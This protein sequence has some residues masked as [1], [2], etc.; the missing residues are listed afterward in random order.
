VSNI[1]DN[2]TLLHDTLRYVYSEK[3]Q[4]WTFDSKGELL[5]TIMS[6]LSQE[7]SRSLSE[8]VTWGLHKRFADGKVSLPYAH[9]TGY[10]KGE[11]GL[12]QVNEQEAETVRL[13]F[14]MFLEGDTPHGI[15]KH[16][17][18][19]GIRTPCGK[20]RWW[21]GTVNSMLKN[22]KYA[23]NALLQKKFTV[24][25]LTKKQ[26]LNEGEVPQ[27]FVENSHQSIIPPETFSMAQREIAR[28]KSST[29]RYS[30]AGMFASKIVCGECGGY[31]GAKVWHSTDKYRRVIYRCNQKFS[32]DKICSTSHITEDE[33]KRLFVSAVNK[34]IVDGGA[35]L[36][37]V[38]MFD[39][40]SL[41]AE[42]LKLEKENSGIAAEIKEWIATNAHTAVDQIAYHKRYDEL[43]AQYKASKTQLAEIDVQR[44]ALTLRKE[45]ADEFLYALGKQGGLIQ[46]FSE[47]LWRSLV[48]C[49]TV[50]ADVDA[51]VAF[52]D[53]TII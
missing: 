13:I 38:A 30:A 19:Q 16:L 29:E 39:T 52:R 49:V 43:D 18:I 22:E 46:E 8:N 42:F 14:R 51:R 47:P 50:Y 20:N 37:D 11:D 36:A 45:N 26:K 7:E 15:A 4:I 40:F 34:L 2:S 41:D 3:E 48:E 53:G 1:K 28:R 35:I 32:G 6:S 10:D 24:D 21:A 27:Y 25:F 17:T 23:G 9:F 31:F 12:P 44:K 33:I 5:I